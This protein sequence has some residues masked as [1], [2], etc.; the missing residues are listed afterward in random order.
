MAT[1]EELANILEAFEED[2]EWDSSASVVENSA[3]QRPKAHDISSDSDDGSDF[4]VTILDSC[5]F[6]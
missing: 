3:H 2:E 4:P 6:D 5:K 1:E